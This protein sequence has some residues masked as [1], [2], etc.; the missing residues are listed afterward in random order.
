[1]HAFTLASSLAALATVALAAPLQS[2]MAACTPPVVSGDIVRIVTSTNCR[3]SPRPV[4]PESLAT[5]SFSG[6]ASL[7]LG[8]YDCEAC[9]AL[10][11]LPNDQSSNSE[12][13]FVA[14]NQTGYYTLECVPRLACPSRR[15]TDLRKQDPK[16]RQ[17][18]HHPHRQRVGLSFRTRSLRLRLPLPGLC[19]SGFRARSGVA[20]LPP[21]PIV[22]V[23]LRRELRSW[24]FVG[25][26]S[27][28]DELDRHGRH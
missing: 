3:S 14:S 24:V 15:S 23:L 20:D 1:M 28:L 16:L 12:L 19:A 17:R 18:V 5:D 8:T 11:L 22:L 25:M 4:S 21:D 13:R 2:R 7:S 6:T 10:E 27:P 9:T 26:P